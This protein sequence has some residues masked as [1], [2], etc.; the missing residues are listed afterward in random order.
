MML[1][2]YIANKLSHDLTKVRVAYIEMVDY[3]ILCK[4]IYGLAQK[5]ITNNFVSTRVKYFSSI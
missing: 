1:S 2:Q 5:K 3:T 4:I